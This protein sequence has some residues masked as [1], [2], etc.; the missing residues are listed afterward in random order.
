MKKLFFAVLVI[1]G[2]FTF[3]P[4]NAQIQISLGLNIGSQPDWGPVG[5]DHAEY[6]YLPDIDAYYYV[7]N[8][9]F[10]YLQGNQW[11]HANNLPPQYGNYDLYNGYKVVV[12]ERNPWQRNSYYRSHYASYR[13]HRG[14]Q[15]IRDSHDARYQNHW[16]GHGNSGFNG[17]GNGNYGRGPGNNGHGYSNGYGHGSDNNR[18]FSNGNG[19][20]QQPSN[21]G[22]GYNGRGQQPGNGQAPGNYGHGQPGNNGQGQGNNGHGQ[23]GNNGQGNNGNGHD[24]GH[25]H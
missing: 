7:P 23:P 17:R 11:I 24:H 1:S 25:G 15:I 21:N 19:R 20:G 13:G 2:C 8:H 16:G 18:G 5:Y 10:V 3:K 9:E 4:A 22:N 14:Q 6:Y 12:N